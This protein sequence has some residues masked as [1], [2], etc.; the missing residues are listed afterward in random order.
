MWESPSASFGHPPQG[1]HSLGIIIHQQNTPSFINI[2]IDGSCDTFF[3]FSSSAIKDPPL[4][5]KPYGN[6]RQNISWHAISYHSN[7]RKAGCASEESVPA[8][9]YRSLHQNQNRQYEPCVPLSR[10][11]LSWTQH[12]NEL[13]ARRMVVFHMAE[14]PTD[15]LVSSI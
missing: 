4:R 10:S 1:Q 6:N 11:S 2:D 9:D 14:R 5:I 13:H 15:T 3:F 8:H 7:G 12:L